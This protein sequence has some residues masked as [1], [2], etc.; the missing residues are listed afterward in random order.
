MELQKRLKKQVTLAI[1]QMVLFMIV[2]A[3]FFIVMLQLVDLM[4]TR[5]HDFN[6]VQDAIG[7]M[8]WKM[9]LLAFVSVVVGIPSLVIW[10]LGI[11]NAIAI[12]TI[13]KESGAL[14]VFAILP[15]GFVHLIIAVIQKNKFSETTAEVVTVKE[16]AA[17]AQ[18]VKT[19]GKKE[20]IDQALL[21][22]V[23]TPEEHKKKLKEL[24]GE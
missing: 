12:N 24:K 14:V 21:N 23:I 19:I 1:W 11:V 22:G 16:T 2:A 18:P 3:T 15:F 7:E 10:I 6:G 5:T 9:I 17:V 4:T 13:T 8:L 20:Q